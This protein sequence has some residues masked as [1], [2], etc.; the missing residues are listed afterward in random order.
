MLLGWSNADVCKWAKDNFGDEIADKFQA[1][2]ITGEMLVKSDRI[3]Q[4][5]TMERLGLKTLGKQEKFTN[6]ISTLKGKNL[7]VTLKS[8]KSVF[9]LCTKGGGGGTT[10]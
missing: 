3:T 9:K 2:E 4:E 7:L 8:Y 6:M 5:N 1:E 10:G